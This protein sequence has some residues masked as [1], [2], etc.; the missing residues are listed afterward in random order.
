MVAGVPLPKGEVLV[1]AG[2]LTTQFFVLVEGE[3]ELV[4]AERR[5]RRSGLRFIAPACSPEK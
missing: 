3:L 2:A 5:R 1:K 4:T